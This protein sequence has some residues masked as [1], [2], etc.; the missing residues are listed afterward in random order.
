MVVI[1][2]RSNYF[3]CCKKRTELEVRYTLLRVC[4]ITGASLQFCFSFFFTSLMKESMITVL[5]QYYINSA[6]ALFLGAEITCN[7]C[8]FFLPPYFLLTLFSSYFYKLQVT[9]THADWCWSLAGVVFSDQ[10]GVLH[11]KLKRPGTRSNWLRPDPDPA[12]HLKYRPEPVKVPGR[13]PGPLWRPLVE[14]HGTQWD[15]AYSSQVAEEPGSDLHKSPG[16]LTRCH[17][18]VISSCA[19]WHHRKN[20]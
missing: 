17:L 2:N 11:T 6:C 9:H 19:Q 16:E 20:H 18:W 7:M 14:M 4:S 8:F 13:V 12:G 5:L 3:F 1:K 15:A 10:L